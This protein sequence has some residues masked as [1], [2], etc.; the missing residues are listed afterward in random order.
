MS[1]TNL[2]IQ[3]FITAYLVTRD[4]FL[5]AACA[6]RPCTTPTNHSPEVW[7]GQKR[8]RMFLGWLHFPASAAGR[9]TP[10]KHFKM[11]ALM[12]TVKWHLFHRHA[13]IKELHAQAQCIP[14]YS[15]LQITIS[16]PKNGQLW[17]YS[18]FL[19]LSPTTPTRL[20]AFC[21]VS[22]KPSKVKF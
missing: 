1:F 18:Q 22:H 2:Q 16:F 11:Q 17:V 10:A 15:A 14:W 13:S 7:L 5:L 19:F 20:L 4:Y 12:M 9:W 3:T 21:K 8:K 6:V